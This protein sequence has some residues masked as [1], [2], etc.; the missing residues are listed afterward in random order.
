MTLIET[1]LSMAQTPFYFIFS[2][3][4]VTLLLLLFAINVN[5][6][7]VALFNVNYYFY[8]F[9]VALIIYKCFLPNLHI[10]C[11]ASE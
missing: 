5:C 8:D 10:F 2:K 1:L 11:I 4:L 9:T 3:L 7:T 6:F